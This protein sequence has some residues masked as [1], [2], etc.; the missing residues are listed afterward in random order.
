M[1]REDFVAVG[2]RLFA[3]YLALSVLWEAARS[4]PLVFE[5]GWSSEAGFFVM[6][7]LLALMIC[8]FLWVFPL[9]VARKLLPVM[10]EPRSEQKLDASVAMSLGLTLIGLWVLGYGLVN[11]AY[12]LTLMVSIYRIGA[13]AYA[14]TP[15]QI[16]GVTATG[17]ELAVGV[18]LVF[19]NAGL[20]RLIYRFRYGA[21]V[22]EAPAAARTDDG[23]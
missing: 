21:S 6:L 17:V 4:A 23:A 22:P 15:E 2:T 14:W 18:W 12:W 8:G 13:E 11:A 1:S 9:T 16:A 3:V 20:K 19:G 5:G 10:R 7:W